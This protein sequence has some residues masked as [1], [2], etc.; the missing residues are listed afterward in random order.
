M[1]DT[2]TIKVQCLGQLGELVSRSP[3]TITCGATV[4]DAIETLAGA[5]QAIA[6]MSQSIALATDDGYLTP[7]AVLTDGMS[8]LVV[9]PISGG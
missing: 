4:A 5:H 3:I 9:P 8:V 7:T 2:V 6:A 1:T